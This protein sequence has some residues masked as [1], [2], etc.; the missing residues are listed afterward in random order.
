LDGISF[1]NRAIIRDAGA[2]RQP[3]NWPCIGARA[4][5]SKLFDGDAGCFQALAVNPPVVGVP[6]MAGFDESSGQVSDGELGGVLML[7]TVNG[8]ILVVL[9]AH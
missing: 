5:S 4:R 1:L 2:R 3:T 7:L 9:G 6:L 8:G